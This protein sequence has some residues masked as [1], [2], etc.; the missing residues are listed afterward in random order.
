MANKHVLKGERGL[1]CSPGVTMC[2]GEQR[3]NFFRA[4]ENSP[5]K[6]MK[7]PQKKLTFTRSRR[8]PLGK[9]ATSLGNNELSSRKGPNS[10]KK[11]C[12][13]S[14]CN[15]NHLKFILY[16]LATYHWNGL[17]KNCNFVIEN[18]SIKIHMKKL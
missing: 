17:K 4:Q 15:Q 9:R 12:F 6:Q 10:I 18:T 3:I 7:F 16:N 13:E 14:F 2:L 11:K 8:C 5:M 1:S